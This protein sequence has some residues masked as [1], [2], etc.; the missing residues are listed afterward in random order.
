MAGESIIEFYERGREEARLT[1]GDGV[2]EYERTRLLLSRLLPPP[3]ARILDVGGGTGRY[4]AWLAD[5]GYQVALVDVVPLHIEQA[6]ARAASGHS[7]EAAVGDAC[8]LDFAD[9][10]FDA[11][12]ALGPFY[13]LPDRGDR[14]RAW[15][16]TVRVVRPGG[17][18]VA[19]AIS[20]LASLLDGA[21]RGIT[22]PAFWTIVERDLR[23][24]QHLPSNDGLYFTT[25][26]FHTPEELLTEATDAGL[27][28]AGLF[29][30]E[31]PFWMLDD[32]DACHASPERWR[33]LMDAIERI[34]S[35]ASAMV[36]SSHILLV[37]TRPEQSKA[38]S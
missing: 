2:L 5:L 19:A 18:V 13:H 25:A 28:C 9:S 3:P 22:D 38:K 30:I 12:I 10:S 20:R 4:A 8:A 15:L 33:V 14:M 31:G 11:V 32:L 37:G 17:I 36:A 29:A 1:S 24:G 34:E 16:E 35:E 23:D 6:K 26:F 7:F 21:H 27:T